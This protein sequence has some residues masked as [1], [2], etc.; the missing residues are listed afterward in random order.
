MQHC[1]L[2]TV[3]RNEKLIRI[4]ERLN[5]SLFTSV[6]NSCGNSFSLLVVFPIVESVETGSGCP[7]G[8]VLFTNNM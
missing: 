3:E 5:S 6:G 4:L 1:I 8:L 7:R 2:L